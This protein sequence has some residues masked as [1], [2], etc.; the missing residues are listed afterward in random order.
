MKT[1]TDAKCY[2]CGKDEKL[3]LVEFT[4]FFCAK[5]RDR[6]EKFLKKGRKT[7]YKNSESYIN[8]HKLKKK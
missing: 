5:C 3:Y 1:N 4:E 7:R 8:A 2:K 6:A